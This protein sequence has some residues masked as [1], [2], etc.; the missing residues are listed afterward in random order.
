ML[1]AAGYPENEH[2]LTEVANHLNIPYQTLRRWYK[3]ESNPVPNDVVQE[4]KKALDIRLEEAA[5]KLLSAILEN[6]D[7]GNIQ[8]QSVA[9]GILVEKMQLLRNEPTERVGYE[10]S[11]DERLA[12]LNAL[13]ERVRNRGIGEPAPARETVH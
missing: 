8:Q 4:Q 10:L 3:G 6:V 13:Y 1:K 9:L 12:R 2:K 7:N 11:D 5:H